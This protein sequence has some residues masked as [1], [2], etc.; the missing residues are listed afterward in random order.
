LGFLGVELV[1]EEA[2]T[3]GISM[4]AGERTVNA[5]GYLHGG[6]ISTVLDVAAYLSLLPELGDDEEAVTHNLSVSYLEA[7][8]GSTRL[9]AIG[10]VV[11]HSRRLAFVT[12]ELRDQA[13]LV[14]TAQVTKSIVSA[15]P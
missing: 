14:A 7:V 9:T 12:A 3:A 2:P 11:R 5:V 1:D 15:P 6:A 4:P 10:S 8:K 13:D